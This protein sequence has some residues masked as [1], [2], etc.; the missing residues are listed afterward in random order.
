M[1]TGLRKRILRT[2]LVALLLAIAARPAA[3]EAPLELKVK[4][5]FL[6]N[7]A[8]YVSWPAGKF[9]DASSPLK[10]CVLEP[11][12]FA[13]VLEET[14]RGKMVETHPVAVAR[15]PQAT[16][17]KDCHIVYSAANDGAAVESAF[18]QLAGAHVVTV[19]DAP[20]ALSDGVIRFFREDRKIRFEI[21]TLA[22]A[23]ENLELSLKLQNL[24]VTVR[25]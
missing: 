22:A 21:N 11:D 20:N 13:G 14:L 9:A 8:R 23:R 10:I 2:G 12:P 7:F 24:A 19:H 1:S 4:A 18:A 25:K 17:L 15:A 5:A 3:A 6:Y 16:D